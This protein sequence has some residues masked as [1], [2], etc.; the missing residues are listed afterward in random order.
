MVLEEATNPANAPPDSFADNAYPSDTDPYSTSNGSP[1]Q[2]NVRIDLSEFPLPPPILGALV[3]YPR[4]RVVGNVTEYMKA[5][6]HVLHRTLTEDEAKALTYHV[7]KASSTSAYGASV[8]ALVAMARCYQTRREFKFPFWNPSSAPGWNP[9]ILGPLKGQA[10]RTAYQLLRIPPYWFIGA[11]TAGILAQSYSTAIGTISIAQDERL[12]ALNEA[13]KQLAK[14]RS[15]LPSRQPAPNAPRPAPASQSDGNG[16]YDDMSPASGSYSESPARS[17]SPKDAASRW[18]QDRPVAP[19]GSYDDASPTGGL[20]P[21]DSGISS[22]GGSAWDRVRQ[23]ASSGQGPP[24]GSSAP[25][26][27]STQKEQRTGSTFGDS[28]TFSS[29][30]EERQ[31]AKAEAQREFDER[32]E[33]ERRGADFNEGSKRW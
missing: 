11:F 18:G 5:A 8:G 15:G 3:G 14:N 26:A 21:F 19:S 31:L 24:S 6:T 33:K 25:W 1:Q 4:S 28:F 17:D 7:A 2:S 22:A 20:G 32:I 30:E 16:M 27:R 10:A 12:K 23:Q 29:S 9:D 13:I